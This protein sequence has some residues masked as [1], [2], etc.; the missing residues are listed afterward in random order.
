MKYIFYIALFLAGCGGPDRNNVNKVADDVGI[1]E[2]SKDTRTKGIAPELLQYVR[3]F[4]AAYGKSIGDITVNFGDTEDKHNSGWCDIRF[5][6][7]RAV[8]ISSKW[9]DIFKSKNT[10]L[11]EPVVWHELG[12]C[13]LNREH[14]SARMP[15]NTVRG[16]SEG[17]ASIMYPTSSWY[18]FNEYR[19]YYIG[20]L[21]R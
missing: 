10:M 3:S 21:F 12:H 17:P 5:D 9:W 11:M 1:D 16:E 18:N 13:V 4:E 19:D 6:G 20:E 7:R 15:I 2:V 8:T 14:T